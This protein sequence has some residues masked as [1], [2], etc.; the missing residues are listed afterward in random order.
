[1]R[2]MVRASRS[3]RAENKK[4]IEIL[5][6]FVT[7]RSD[8]CSREQSMPQKHGLSVKVMRRM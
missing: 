2:V 8:Y 5:R 4:D 1:M 3:R 6:I 7:N